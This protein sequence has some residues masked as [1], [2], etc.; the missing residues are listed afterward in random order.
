MKKLSVVL[1]LVIAVMAMAVAPVFG[2]DRDYDAIDPAE[3]EGQ[4]VTFWHQH[5][6]FREVQLNVLI[7]VFNDPDI[8]GEELIAASGYAGTDADER[9]RLQAIADAVRDYAREYNPFGIIVNPS[10]QGGYGD[11]F[12]KM[13]TELAAGGSE[14]PSLVVAYQNQ[15]A[16][17]QVV[18]GLID[19]TPL[20]ESPIWGLAEEDIADF[21]PGFWAQDIFPTFDNMRLA[22]PPN[23]SMEVMYYNIDWLA[24]LAEAGAISFD[25][26]PT[27]PEQFAEAACAAVENPFSGATGAESPLGYQLSMD[28]SR[29]ASWTFAFGG[30]IFDYD[31][32]QYSLDSDAAVEAISFLR[33]LFDQGCAGEVFERFGDQANFGAGTTLFTVG[34]S[35]G[36]PF[37]G[38]A[39]DAGAGHA[40]SVAAIPH[41]TEQPVQNVYGASVSIPVTDPVQELATW[42]FLKFYTDP[43][44]NA[45]WAESSNYFPVRISSAESMDSYFEAN[46]AYATAFELL[47]FVRAEPPVPGYDPVR[48]EM[49]SVMQA[50]TTSSDPRPVAEILADLNEVANEQ[51]EIS[52]AGLDLI[53]D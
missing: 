5:S 35:S 46:P 43:F 50:A 14:L 15:S 47:P 10:N 25:G 45:V 18:D 12:S 28:A 44:V 21:F 34:S 19:M 4:V 23:R 9:E 39:V 33:D 3:L 8:T 38:N 27:T 40:W 41:V 37:Y 24:E 53:I 42:L 30:D 51:L 31:A 16:T 17:Y 22:F 52:S 2:Q 29:F 26:P 48:N 32:V 11:I 1:T 13:T 49:A 20:V 7:A 36:L 6:G